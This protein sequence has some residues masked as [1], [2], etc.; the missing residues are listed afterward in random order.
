[1]MNIDTVLE[2]YHSLCP[3]LER[4]VIDLIIYIQRDQNI[5]SV[6]LNRK[7]ANYFH[8][9][10]CV[11]EVETIMMSKVHVTFATFMLYFTSINL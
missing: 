4:D 3:F 9:C 7:L 8:K 1:M 11:V 10:H 2:K 6:Y 5:C